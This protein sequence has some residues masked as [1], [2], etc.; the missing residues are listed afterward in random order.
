[1]PSF[2]DWEC[3][4]TAMPAEVRYDGGSE[5]DRK[6]LP[7]VRRRRKKDATDCTAA[8]AVAAALGERQAATSH[9]GSDYV[10]AKIKRITS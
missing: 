3:I 5:A 6:R 10:S 1:M 8:Q 7:A 9:D 4:I 2:M